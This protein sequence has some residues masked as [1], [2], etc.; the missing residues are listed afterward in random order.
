VKFLLRALLRA[1]LA[2]PWR[3][4]A[5]SLLIA[6]LLALGATRVER[7]LDLMSLLPKGDP[8]VKANLEA[9][10][11]QQELIWLVAE[12]N[13][14]DLEAREAW[15]EGLLDKL[16]TGSGLPLNGLAAEGRLSDPVFVPSKQGVSPWPAL[17][18]AGAVPDGD[19]AVDRLLT[20]TLYALAPAWLGDRLA[21]L[22]DPAE[23]KARLAATAKD[24]AS[25]DP[26]RANLARLDPLNIRGLAPDGATG[27]GQAQA[28]AKRFSL[29]L[30]TGYLE[31]KDGRFV[32]VPLVAG[33]PTTDTKT[34]ARVL[35]WLGRGA[36]GPLPP[37]ASLKAVEAACAPSAG[38]AFHIQATGAHAV[39]AWESARLTR[40]VL[41]SLGLS[42]VLIG[43]VYFVGFRTFAGYGFVMVP[44]LAGMVC[45]LGLTGWTL[46]R[47]NLMAA[48]FGA[49]L[50][51]V[52]DDV[53]ILLFSR[54]RDERQR[55]RTKARALREA[56]LGTGPGVV[57][58]S[59]T[60]ALAFL[61][62][63]IAPFPGIR[64]LGLTT[65]LGLLCCLIA[66]FILMPP[67]LLRFD[68]GKGAFAPRAAKAEKARPLSRWKPIAALALLGFALLGAPRTRWEEDLR[69]FRMADNPALALQEQLQGVLGASLRPLALEIPLGDPDRLPLRW[70]KL[71]PLLRAEGVPLPDWQT[72][73]P[74]L[75]AVLGSDT[76]RQQTL[77]I[78]NAEGL[79]P[80]A[81]EGP[82]RTLGGAARDP[83]VPVEAMLALLPRS[84]SESAGAQAL[85]LPLRLDDAAEDRLAADLQKV[86]LDDSGARLV[87]IRPLLQVVKAIAKNSIQEAVLLSLAAVL[88]IIAL[89]GR[90][91][92]FAA[93][94]LAPLLASQAGV[95]GALGWTGEPLTFLSLTAIP[96]AL[97][98]SVDTAFNLLH[99][100][101]HEAD[102]ASR[103][104]RVNAVCAG[105]TLAG[106]GGLAFSSYR[107]L[108][109]V[110]I[111][112]LG[113]VALALLLTQWLLP[114]MLKRWD[115]R[116]GK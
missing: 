30:K 13:G 20:E 24:L 59:V 110:G 108:R 95:F 43:L 99:R 98:V 80:V 26:V 33:F 1:Q 113:G 104:A 71:A 29:K 66:T 17:L 2:R 15:A 14:G 79:D 101:R 44:L 12:G 83:K 88:L 67:L 74:R 75:R 11:G 55:A 112:C 91:W 68:H 73:D 105:T 96:I 53:G 3:L 97:G 46:G 9:G 72:P 10:V 115:L 114:M 6:V 61:A 107:A 35:A 32:L 49:V 34:T 102:A 28:A 8:A 31:S 41:L 21:P 60:T 85:T 36:E 93:L 22:Q 27:L 38:R 18:A 42:F 58:G 94:A 5:P 39:T 63:A 54:Y 45:A 52:G 81:L 16:L 56:L 77:D 109:G 19:A 106:F 23:V 84:S 82:L 78:A 50:L 116:S 103:V 25:L 7:Q 40:E 51:G 69:K 92:R 70:N 37:R 76:W 90:S 64:D 89:F 87:G 65:G 111:A 4:L 62:L 100:A 57:A 48:G 86:R 47:L